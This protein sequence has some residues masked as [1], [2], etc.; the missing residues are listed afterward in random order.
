ML[1]LDDSDVYGQEDFSVLELKESSNPEMLILDLSAQSGTCF[2]LSQV[3]ARQ[4]RDELNKF[5]KK[6][7]L[8]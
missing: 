2:W 8:Y 5:L 7:Q 3:T 6:N 4:L 1:R